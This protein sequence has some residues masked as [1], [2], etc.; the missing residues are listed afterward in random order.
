MQDSKRLIAAVLAS[1]ICVVPI[2][3]VM[4][5]L[6]G[7]LDTDRLIPVLMMMPVFAFIGVLLVGLPMHFFLCG[8]ACH[9]RFTTAYWA[10]SFQRYL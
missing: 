3:F 4:S 1:T 7:D 6:T 9:D 10:L 8:G 5:V 2:Y